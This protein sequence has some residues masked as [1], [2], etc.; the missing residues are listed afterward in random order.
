M[1]QLQQPG[2]AILRTHG[3]TPMLISI[4]LCTRED[5]Q[6]VANML[7]APGK[8]AITPTSQVAA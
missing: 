4:P 6:T 5:M 7:K 1:K 2:D 3:D 8:E